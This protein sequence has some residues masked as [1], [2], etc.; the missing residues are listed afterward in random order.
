MQLI[1]KRSQIKIKTID[2]Y[3][4]NCND[5]IF[6]NFVKCTVTKNL[7]YLIISGTPAKDKL[8][9]AWNEIT[10]SYQDLAKDSTSDYLLNLFCQ[11]SYLDER[12]RIVYNIIAY[13]EVNRSEGLIEVLQNDLGFNYSY[14]EETMLQDLKLTLSE[15]KM[16][17]VNL[18]L[19]EI[20]LKAY[21]EKNVEPT[22]IDYDRLLTR[23]SKYQGYQLKSKEI[24]VTQFVSILNDYSAKN[25]PG[26]LEPTE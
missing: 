16:D 23:L 13:L 21:R 3:Y 4:D 22:E 12:L 14:S 20:E 10:N 17:K 15:C 2:A 18:D 11:I 1:K 19:S 9:A 5:L 6:W 8:I 24:T 7:N 25:Q 26:K